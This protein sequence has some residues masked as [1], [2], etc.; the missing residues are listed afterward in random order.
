VADGE[1]W[2]VA[3]VALA[4]AETADGLCLRLHLLPADGGD[5]EAA[6]QRRAQLP[7]LVGRASHERNNASAA[8]CGAQ[9][10]EKGGKKKGKQKGKKKGKEKTRQDK[11]R[12]EKKEKR[13]EKK[14]KKERKEGRFHDDDDEKES[15]KHF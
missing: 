3:F 13:K 10:E 8:H 2:D 7:D 9:G 12:K 4:A 11:T 6:R 1:T 14:R 15:C 5:H